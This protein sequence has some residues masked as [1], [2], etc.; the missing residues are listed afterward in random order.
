VS[1]WYATD[2][3]GG[4]F[5]S[6]KALREFVAAHPDDVRLEDTSL[7]ENKGVH[8]GLA[9]ADLRR[10]DVIVGP[11]PWNNRRWYANVRNGKIV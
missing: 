2:A 6:K 7:I 8:Y 9:S 10:S 11:N 1:D 4:D 3:G 5:P